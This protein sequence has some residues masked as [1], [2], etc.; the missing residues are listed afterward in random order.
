M[1]EENYNQES[2]L[3]GEVKSIIFR[4]QDNL[5]S[6]LK[7]FVEE[8]DQTLDEDIITVTGYFPVLHEDDVYTFHGSFI[9]HPKFGNQFQANRFQ[10]QQPQTKSGIIRYLSS[11]LFKGIGPKTAESI[12]DELGNQAISLILQDPSVLGKIKKLSKQKRIDLVESLKEHQGIE[13]MMIHLN[14][15]GFGPQLSTKIY[16]KYRDEAIEIIQT[17]PYRLVDDIKGI[18]FARADEIGQY[19]GLSGNHP[20]RINAGILF[21]LEQE[22]SQEGHA[23][24]QID[25]LGEKARQLL[26]HNSNISINEIHNQLSLLEEQKKIMKDDQRVYLPSLYFSEKGLSREIKRLMKQTEYKDLFPESEFLMALGNL[27]ERLN[28]EYAPLQ[29]D[30]IQRALQSPITILTGGPG[31]GKTTV[32]KGIVELYSELHGCSLDDKD[33]KKKNEPFPILLAAPTGRAA[34]RMAEATNIA[35]VTIH[36]LLGWNGVDGFQHNEDNPIQGKL[37]IIDEMSMVDIFLANQLFKALPDHIQVVLVGDE[38]QLPSVGPGQVLKDLIRSNIMETVKLTDIY[39]QA[40][41]STIIELAHKINQGNLPEDVLHP[42]SDRS[43][44]ECGADQMKEVVHKVVKN[45]IHKGLSKKDIQVLAPMYKGPVGINQLNLM[46]QE[47][48]NPP[49]NQKRELSFGEVVYRVGDKVLQLV[50]QPESNVFN[51]DM[52]FIV[53]IFYSKE[54]TEKEDLIVISFDGIEVTYT[55]KDFQQFTHAYCCSIHKAQGSEFPVVI[56]PVLR[57]YYRM[58]KRN[59]IYTAITRSKKYL[60]MCGELEVFKR[61]IQNG[62]EDIRQTSLVDRLLDIEKAPMSI[63]LMQL[64]KELPFNVEDASVGMEN[65]SPFDFMDELG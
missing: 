53:S 47:M 9:K 22:T 55:R 26:N 5:Y 65:I 37:L 64:Q 41:G 24:L 1:K 60:I 7:I 28:V 52:G 20:D 35:A 36:R 62:S 57:S 39:R 61:G 31:T 45:A 6:V 56:L 12:V 51:G 49:S 17:N 30:G 34:K 63:E 33:Y 8:S 32:I 10:K 48:L 58:L 46:L 38:D 11:D 3:T 44:I 29:K 15:F 16:Q 59:L 54:N 40:E 19:F 18:G 23:F 14:E 50:N 13:Q 42:T 27:E 25:Q 21:I 43:F 4:N 2:F